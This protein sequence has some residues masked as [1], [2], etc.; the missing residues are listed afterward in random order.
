MQVSSSGCESYQWS[1]DGQPLL[2]GAD[3]SGV[4]SNI[5]YIDRVSK[6]T[7]RM[8]ACCVCNG[9][10]NIC[11][12][13]I[14]LMVI[15][16][17]IEEMDLV[18]LLDCLVNSEVEVISRCIYNKIASLDQVHLEPDIKVRYLLQQVCER[19][20][21]DGKVYDRLVR[22][23]RRLDETLRDICNIMRKRVDRD[24]EDKVG[25]AGTK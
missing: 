8:Y 13:E 20:R 25:Y 22:V 16:L 14:N 10:R 19:V 6:G 4:S 17:S 15:K 18:K 7:E 3:F 2:D 1:K 21:E 9:S 24:K 5:L 23:L 11:S 12:D